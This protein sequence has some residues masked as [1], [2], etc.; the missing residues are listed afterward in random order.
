M[1]CDINLLFES[2]KGSNDP[3][4]KG[5]SKSKLVQL[6]QQIN[7][8]SQNAGAQLNLGDGNSLRNHFAIHQMRDI[9]QI[10]VKKINKN[11]PEED[12]K[13]NMDPEGAR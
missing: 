3:S 8:F 10:E 13:E 11:L 12:N 2:T 6:S 1:S 5:S 9:S 7:A 4:S